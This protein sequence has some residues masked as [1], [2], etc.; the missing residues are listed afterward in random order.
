VIRSAFF[1]ALVF[2]S[3]RVFVA[4]FARTRTG[5]QTALL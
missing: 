3:R 4:A 1:H 5:Q 2:N